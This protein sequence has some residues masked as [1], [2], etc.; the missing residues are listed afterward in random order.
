MDKEIK[1]CNTIGETSFYPNTTIFFNGS[2]SYTMG[3]LI[4]LPFASSKLWENFPKFG[5]L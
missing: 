1:E 2:S 3:H 5:M 4:T